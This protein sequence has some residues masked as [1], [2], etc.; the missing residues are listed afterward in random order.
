MSRKKKTESGVLFG[1]W[2]PAQPVTVPVAP[3][4]APVLIEPEPPPALVI[5]PVR[6]PEPSPPPPTST[7]RLPDCAEGV[8]VE[9]TNRGDFVVSR[10][11]HGGTTACAVHYTRTELE[12]LR[13]RIDT[14]LEVG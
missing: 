1:S 12:Q 9:A 14:A 4:S 3:P 7:T 8:T 5:E 2:A 6:E 10:L 13:H 11:R